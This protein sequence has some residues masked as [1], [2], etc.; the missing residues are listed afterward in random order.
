ML[1]H[2]IASPGMPRGNLKKKERK[3]FS[4]FT[5]TPSKYILK[6]AQNLQQLKLEVHL[7]SK[8]G[9]EREIS[10]DADPGPLHGFMHSYF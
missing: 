5:S 7:L 9:S 6:E 4:T 8:F 10:I 2:S 1:I 3:S